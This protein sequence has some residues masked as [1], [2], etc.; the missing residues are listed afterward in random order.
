MLKKSNSS[1]LQHLLPKMV[2]EVCVMA[3]RLPSGAGRVVR[4]SSRPVAGLPSSVR[5]SAP[6][7]WRSARV[8]RSDPMPR[9]YNKGVMCPVGPCISAWVFQFIYIMC[10]RDCNFVSWSGGEPRYLA[11]LGSKTVFRASNLSKTVP[12]SLHFSPFFCSKFKKTEFVLKK[13]LEVCQKTF[14]FALEFLGLPRR[15][16]RDSPRELIFYTIYLFIHLH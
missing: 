16:F 2:S 14:K 7:V 8:A 4:S 9:I 6:A 15:A 5:P 3:V 10:H 1:R 12:N 13:D 11:C